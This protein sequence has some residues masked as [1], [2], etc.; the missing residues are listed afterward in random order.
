MKLKLRH[1]VLCA[2]VTL[3][4]IIPMV[5]ADVYAAPREVKVGAI[6]PLTGGQ[7]PTGQDAKNAI[8][9]AELIINGVY[10]L[11]LPLA[12][13][14]GLP[15]LGGATVKFVMGDS[16]ASPEKGMAEA[17]RLITGQ[18]VS[19]IL[20]CYN[21]NVTV[22]ASQVAERFRIPFLNPD[23]TSPVLNKRGLTWFFRTTP[24]D[25]TFVEDFFR[26][27]KDLEARGIKIQS[28]ASVCQNALS[29]VDNANL[30]KRFAQ[31]YGFK[32]VEAQLFTPNSADLSS[33]IQRLKAARPDVLIAHAEIADAMLLTKQ[34]K[35]LDF[36]PDAVVASAAGFV[37]A[38][39]LGTLGREADYII[40][41]EVFSL[42]FAAKK[43][44][45]K[46]VNDL[47]RSRYGKDM[48]GHNARVFMGALVLADAIN[49]AG[50]TEPEAIRRAL[51]ATDIPA[52]QVIMPW[53]GI[54]F[55]KT[56][57]NTLGNGILVQVQ[58]GVYRTVWPWDV[59]T[60]ELVWP[61]PVWSKR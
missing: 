57:Q 12:K 25:E 8:E 48:N 10:D 37:V 1:L 53:R 26:F 3:L 24:D 16:Q 18:K 13:S 28:V 47:Y 60:A 35:E 15:N 6:Y 2:V 58:K 44:I 14:A 33:E 20:G 9:L 50:S 21:S 55:D 32:L 29:G 5:A 17:E 42:D 11:N 23:S 51:A 46:A 36:N 30:I 43:P 7:A 22:P 61:A 40:S 59:A 39:Y 52:D 19:A 56:G 31:Q 34:L 27:F 38:E 41:R 45:V 4:T 54:R 49:R